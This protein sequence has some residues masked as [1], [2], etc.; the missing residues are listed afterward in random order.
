VFVLDSVSCAD[1]F[2]ADGA[3]GGA[4]IVAQNGST[5]GFFTVTGNDAYVQLAYQAAAGQALE[6]TPP[7]HVGTGNG[8]LAAGTRG[9]RFANYVAGSV[10]VVSAGLSEPLEP[11]LQLTS[12][13][14]SAP[15]VPVVTTLAYT[16]YT[17]PV[18]V[19]SALPVMTPIVACPAVPTDGVTPITVTF[20]SPAIRATGAGGA[21]GSCYVELFQDGVVMGIIC[22]ATSVNAN[23]DG[24]SCLVSRVFTPPAG[25]HT[26]TVQAAKDGG[27]MNY[28]VNAGVGGASGVF[29]PGF[30][31]ITSGG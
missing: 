1:A 14:V 13:G 28:N 27:G 19:T 6:W 30:L 29:V 11:P 21:A 26:Y 3:A 16:E 17:A 23:T 18:A 7:V 22:L 8:I 12:A 2:P 10:A 4:Q 24:T 31:K 25:S 15:T 5:G 9:I 20:F